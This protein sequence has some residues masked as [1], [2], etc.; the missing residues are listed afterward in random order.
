M[1]SRPKGR[2]KRWR[3]AA[4]ASPRAWALLVAAARGVRRA[5]AADAAA[6][7]WEKLPPAPAGFQEGSAVRVG[8]EVWFIGGYP[9]DRGHVWV[10]DVT[11]RTWR[12]GPELP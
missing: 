4:A 2:T 10:F 1:S 6:A 5:D 3:A 9:V 7:R 12:A 8:N 11:T